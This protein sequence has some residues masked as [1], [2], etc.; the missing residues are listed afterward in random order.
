VKILADRNIALVKEAFAELGE[1]TTL[2]GSAIDADQVRDAELLL[3]RS[4][5]KVGRSLLAHSRVRFVATATIGIDHLDTGWLAERGIPWASAPGS[6]ADS[7]VQWFAAALLALGFDPA[8][9]R[10][11]VVGVGNVGR[12]ILRLAEALATLSGGPPPL[13]CDPPR[14]RVEGPAGWVALEPLLEA[15]DLVTLH[16]PLLRDGPDATV[17]LLDRARLALLRPGAVLVNASRGEVIEPAALLE[18]RARLSA[19][20]L[21][22]FPGEPRPEPALVAACTIATPHIAGHSL[23]GKLNG[24]RMI[25]AAACAWLRHEARFTPALPPPEPADLLIDPATPAPRAL[26][27]ALRAGYPIARDHAALAAILQGPDPGAGFSQYRNQYPV[28]RELSAYNLRIHQS[29]QE[30]PRLLATIC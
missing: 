6:N 22:V 1:V 12:R 27:E 3:C 28:R 17:R 2:P 10:I 8:N 13:A 5:I 15:C 20:A 16:V 9:R 7:V 4:T 19:L 14:A 25:H 29:L 18:A 30:L 26:L 23:D 21:D 24:T 11:G